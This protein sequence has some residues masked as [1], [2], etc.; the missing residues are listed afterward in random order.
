M[1]A[2]EAS[3]GM[4]TVQV[5]S[6]A[7]PVREFGRPWRIRGLHGP[8]RVAPQKM[9]LGKSTTSRGR[10][11]GAE[12]WGA[13]EALTLGGALECWMEP[14]GALERTCEEPALGSTGEER[15]QEDAGEERPPGG[16]GEERALGLGSN[17]SP[18]MPP[19]SPGAHEPL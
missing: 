7:V 8:L 5:A 4:E 9:F 13:L 2:L 17:T 11:G 18:L 10:S 6:R 14:A 3:R 12:V 1:G 19:T 15:T 16:I